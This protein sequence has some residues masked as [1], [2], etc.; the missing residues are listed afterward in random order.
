MAGIRPSE[1]NQDI[2]D[3]ICD[4]LAEGESLRRIC[5]SDGFPVQSTVFKWLRVFADFEQQYVRAREAQADTMA[6]EILDIAD[7]L[8]GEGGEDVQR[9]KLRVD[10]RKWLASKMQ[11]KK[12]GDKTL[13]GSDPENPIPAGFVVNLKGTNGP[14]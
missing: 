3:A 2:A 5:A 7:D 12:Y 8:T 11:P 10:A 1:F 13:I 9:S 14:A 4:R 6:D